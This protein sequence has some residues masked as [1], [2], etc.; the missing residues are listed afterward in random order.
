MDKQSFLASLR[1]AVSTL[2]PDEIERTVAY[3][4][5]LIEDRMEDG[6]SEE[7]AVG[8]MEP[9]V[10]LA[11]K[12]FESYRTPPALR[13]NGAGGGQAG[14]GQSAPPPQKRRGHVLLVILAVL[15]SPVWIPVMLALGAAALVVIA[16]M[17][18]AIIVIIAAVLSLIFGSVAVFILWLLGLVEHTIPVLFVIGGLLASIGLGLL[19]LFPAIALVKLIWR[20]IKAFCRWL[21][22]LFRRKKRAVT[23]DVPPRAENGENKEA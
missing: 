5:E 14:G 6:M 22:S 19:L 8:S 4:E 2:P 10:T 7:E 11:S 21:G 13:D 3:Y 17:F 9:I 1:S 20:G 18:V 16:V 23:K 15:G 12:A